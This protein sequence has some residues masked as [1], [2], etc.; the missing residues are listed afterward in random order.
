MAY[1][2]D[3]IVKNQNQVQIGHRY[4]VAKCLSGPFIGR[5]KDAIGVLTGR[6]DAIKFAEVEAKKDPNYTP[7]L[8]TDKEIA[9]TVKEVNKA[10][11]TQQ[12]GIKFTEDD[13][14]KMGRNEPCI[15]GSGKKF[16][17]CCGTNE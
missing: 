12:T 7:L 15:C 3:E 10:S 1:F 8:M 5:L 2:A 14:L 13:K 16:K 9:D 6:Y 11:I 17:R 4:Y